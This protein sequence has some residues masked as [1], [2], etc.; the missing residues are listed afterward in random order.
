MS[1]VDSTI[2]MNGRF[3][4]LFKSKNPN[5]SDIEIMSYFP[6]YR[7]NTNNKIKIAKPAGNYDRL[8]RYIDANGKVYLTDYKNI[9][10]TEIQLN[11][12]SKNKITK[13][14]V[15]GRLDDVVITKE[16]IKTFNPSNDW[17]D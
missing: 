11:L 6:D 13:E 8:Y 10:P 1:I 5:M 15:E 7:P 4:R 12:S 3:E 17:D 2:I 9:I 14:L 16:H